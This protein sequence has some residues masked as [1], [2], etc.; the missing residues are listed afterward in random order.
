MSKTHLFILGCTAMLILAACNAIGESEVIVGADDAG[1]T[2]ELA[3]DDTL[4]IELEGNPSTGY[5]WEVGAL[6]TAVLAP[7]GEVQFTPQSDLVGASG[8]VILRFQAMGAGESEL[9]LI[10]HRPWE[11]DVEPLETFTINVIV[12]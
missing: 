3:V 1:T 11:E 6:D 9:S 8:I 5:S 2:V 7:V 4:V 12:H 10:Y